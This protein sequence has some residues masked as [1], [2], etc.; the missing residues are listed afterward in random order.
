MTTLADICA[1]EGCGLLSPSPW[2]LRNQCALAYLR[3]HYLTPNDALYVRNHAPVPVGGD[4][5]TDE[6]S[7][8]ISKHHEIRRL[9]PGKKGSVDTADPGHTRHLSSM[10]LNTLTKRFGFK[11]VTS[12]LQCGGSRAREDLAIHGRGGFTGTNTESITCGMIGNAQ[13]GGVPLAAVVRDIYPK[14]VLDAAA[15]AQGNYHLEFHGADQYYASIPLAHVL[16]EANDCLLCTI[17]NGE[18]LPRDHGY[19]ARILMP[20]T[21]GMEH[22]YNIQY[23]DSYVHTEK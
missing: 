12:V 9:L 18:E 10:S 2:Q 19:P 8:H 4:A 11:T 14:K 1:P 21:V 13:W 23:S 20:G 5:A 22:L 7:F 17:M 15:K 16:D 3:S 6:V